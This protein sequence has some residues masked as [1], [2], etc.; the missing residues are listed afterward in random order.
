MT[1][2]KGAKLRRAELA[3]RWYPNVKTEVL[4]TIGS[5]G[6]YFGKDEEQKEFNVKNRDKVL[7]VVPHAG[8]YFS[9][10]LAAKTLNIAS[11]LF[12][13]KAPSHVVI[14]GG[15]LP[16]NAPT[17]NYLEEAWETPLSPVTLSPNLISLLSEGSGSSIGFKTWQGQTNDNTIEV[18][19]PLIKH[20]F[21]EAEVL[22]LRVAPDESSISLANALIELLK[23][24]KSLFVASTD[25][26]HYG[27]SYGFCPAGIGPKGD[28]FREKND[29][30]FI[31]A[32]LSLNTKEI[33][34]LGNI[35]HAAC[36][37]GAAS[38]VAKI[39]SLIDAKGVLVDYYASSDIMPGE[40]SVG[41]AGI[42][43]ADN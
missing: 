17:I 35:N 7:A 20:F 34:S 27:L 6:N 31:D 37:S 2:N 10:K 13:K 24:K 12:G 5:W 9:G 1:E 18:E 8:W 43:Y 33:L 3:G 11:K 22:A 4:E 39:A 19:L 38:T 28:K 21:P 42:V 40:Q 16:S 41:Y 26:T 25:L 32:A 30:A 14:L 29:K 36:S 23:D 15:H